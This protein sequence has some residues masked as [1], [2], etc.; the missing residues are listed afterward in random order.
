M[1]GWHRSASLG[2]AGGAV[3]DA[4]VAAT[5]AEHGITLATR[6]RRAAE[7]YHDL[8]IDFELID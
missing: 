7:T 4:L 2:I 1:P 5:A 6:D 3:Y 8:D